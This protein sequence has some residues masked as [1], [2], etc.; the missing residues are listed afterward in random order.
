MEQTIG[1]LRNELVDYTDMKLN[2][3]R[4]IFSDTKEN[5]LDTTVF[6]PLGNIYPSNKINVKLPY[7][8]SGDEKIFKKEYFCNNLYSQQIKYAIKY[9]Q[10][11]ALKKF[12]I[13]NHTNVLL[14]NPFTVL[15]DTNYPIDKNLDAIKQ[16]IQILIDNYDEHY[17]MICNIAEYIKPEQEYIIELLYT[18]LPNDINNICMI[19]HSTEPKKL[20]IC[21]CLC[22]TPTH[23]S[24]LVKMSNYKKLDKCSVCKGNYKLNEPIY[25]TQSGINIK[26]I[27]DETI[28]FPFNDMYYM[29]LISKH[30]L[31]KVVGMGRLDFAI[32]YLQVERVKE[33]LNDMEILDNLPNYYFG[34][35]EHKQTPLIALAQGNMPSNAHIS[36]GNNK[37]KYIKIIEMLLDTKKIDLSVK[38]MFGKTFY[39]Y[40]NKND[41]LKNISFLNKDTIKC[42]YDDYVNNKRKISFQEFMIIKDMIKENDYMFKVKIE[43]IKEPVYYVTDSYVLKQQSGC[44]NYTEIKEILDNNIDAYVLTYREFTPRDY[45]IYNINEY[46]KS[47]N[48]LKYKELVNC[49]LYDHCYYVYKDKYNNV[50]DFLQKQ[51]TYGKVLILHPFEWFQIK[52]NTRHNLYNYN[53]YT[54]ISHP[55]NQQYKS[56]IFNI[57][58]ILIDIDGTKEKWYDKIMT[59]NN[60]KFN[61]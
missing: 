24:C 52:T 61:L 27:L 59:E 23:A 46:S 54:Q 8:F 36:F 39:D 47:F 17:N 9:I 49:K 31:I 53:K 32:L 25:R 41:H 48:D 21:T 12:I 7:L 35:K 6:Y 40:I 15:L 29:P 28:F 22:K 14:Q 5:I 37:K 18:F 45:H 4:I 10:V 2:E 56:N 44:N 16:I 55:Q 3:P 60:I 50:D 42:I 38:D 26:E 1:E 58:M 43:L 30:N 13:K 11:N 33:L 20:L 51:Q 19:C 57:N 34:D